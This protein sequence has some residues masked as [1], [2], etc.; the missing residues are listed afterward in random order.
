MK[1]KIHPLP[2]AKG[3]ILG[4]GTGISREILLGAELH[5]IHEDRDDD[6]PL[7]SIR[8]GKSSGTP[9]EPGMPFMQ[10]S[11]GRDKDNG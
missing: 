6:T 5:R 4:K 2:L 8:S 1:E 11:H 10:G 9:D 3:H 7:L